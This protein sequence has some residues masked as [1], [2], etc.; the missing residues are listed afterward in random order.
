M[1]GTEGGGVRKIPRII[2]KRSRSAVTFYAF[3]TYVCA[4]RTRKS[5]RQSWDFLV[6]PLYR[7]IQLYL[8]HPS[9]L[10]LKN[11]NNKYL[12]EKDWQ[13]DFFKS[14]KKICDSGWHVH[15]YL[16]SSIVSDTNAMRSLARRRHGGRLSR[17]TP[18]CTP[19]GH[20][21]GR[22]RWIDRG[23]WCKPRKGERQK[24][25]VYISNLECI[26]SIYYAVF[27]YMG[28]STYM[29]CTA[30][31]MSLIFGIVLNFG[32]AAGKL[33]KKFIILTYKAQFLFQ[34][35]NPQDSL[36]WIWIDFSPN[37]IIGAVFNFEICAPELKKRILNMI[38]YMI[39]KMYEMI[40]WKYD[41][42]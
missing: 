32:F 11:N 10:R 18:I 4:V 27:I 42:T 14:L 2:G 37:V 6:L 26:R 30:F 3:V 5:N 40:L 36:G 13:D 8:L 15:T 9:T 39:Y 12:K 31:L 35:S 21:K 17:R 23:L 20:C 22:E 24:L 33:K 38:V 29:I 41:F 28:Y 25:Y 34:F 1:L 19:R 7:S 16:Y